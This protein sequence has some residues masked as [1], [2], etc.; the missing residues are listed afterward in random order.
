MFMIPKI[1][2]YC[3]F[4]GK[5]LPANVKKC[6]ASWKK[7]CPDFEIKQWDE[8]NFDLNSC[9][10]VQEAASKKKWAFVSD[11][12]RFW[13][14]YNYGGLYLDTDVEIIKPLYPI[15]NKGPYMGCEEVGMVN[16]GL[17]MA[18]IPRMNLLEE[19]LQ[20]YSSQHFLNEDGTENEETVV[21]KVTRLLVRYGFE[22]KNSIQKVKGMV[23][24]PPKYFCPI[25]Y[26]TGEE[27]VTSNTYSIHHYDAS[28][29]T[30]L[31]K[32]VIILEQNKKSKFY[33][34]R[35]FISVQLRVVIRIKREGMI[36]TIKYCCQKIS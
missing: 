3:W 19:I 4:G 5:D 12:A 13:I 24:Y 22:K 6:I 29:H 32:I 31:E 28:W 7:Y 2:H 34:V 23:I 1:I 14:L 17:G 15:L 20:Y 33:I 18:A 35:R 11:Y 16:P 10:Y 27:K 25:N 21:T 30:G 9:K 8:S 26:K 36:N